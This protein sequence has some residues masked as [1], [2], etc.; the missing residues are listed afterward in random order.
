MNVGLIHQFHVMNQF[1]TTVL[2]N[3]I[4]VKLLSNI[5]CVHKGQHVLWKDGL[6]TLAHPN[7]MLDMFGYQRI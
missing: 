7:D 6:G 3:Y 4:F 5:L 2:L 1:S